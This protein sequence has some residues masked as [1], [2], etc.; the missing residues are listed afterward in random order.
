MKKLGKLEINPGKLM[1]KEELI[2]LRGGYNWLCYCYNDNNLLG[3]ISD[4]SCEAG[5]SYLG[6]W[7][8]YAQVSS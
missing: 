6:Y 7:T 1:K 3:V 4:I 2:S 5:C 8:S